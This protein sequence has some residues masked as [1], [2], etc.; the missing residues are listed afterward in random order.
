MQRAEPKADGIDT[1]A[2][3]ADVAERARAAPPAVSI[4]STGPRLPLMRAFVDPKDNPDDTPCVADPLGGYRASRTSSTAWRSTPHR[5]RPIRPRSGKLTF[6][7]SRDNGSV[8]AALCGVADGDA[9]RR[10]RPR[11]R[12]RLLRRPVGRGHRPALRAAR[13]CRA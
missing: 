5:R 3:A 6:K 8:V 2:K 10:G 4:A 7:W 1:A 12:A 9:D 11:H 13:A